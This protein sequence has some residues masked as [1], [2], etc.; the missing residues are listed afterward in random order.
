MEDSCVWL[1]NGEPV[2]IV[3]IA[4]R[5]ALAR[6]A[7]FAIVPPLRGKGLARTMLAPLFATLKTKGVARFIW[8]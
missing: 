7:A 5:D 2:A 1:Q 6:L 8:K 4:R 3:I